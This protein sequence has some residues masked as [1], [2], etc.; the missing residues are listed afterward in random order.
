MLQLPVWLAK[1]ESEAILNYNIALGIPRIPLSCENGTDA[2]TSCLAR[3]TGSEA[4][5]NITI[6]LIIPW[7]VVW[8]VLL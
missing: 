3:K 7:M 4:I 5:L 8:V 2:G 1:T 6:V